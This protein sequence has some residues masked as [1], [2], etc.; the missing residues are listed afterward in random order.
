MS[1]SKPGNCSLK[2]RANLQVLDDRPV[3]PLA[4]DQQR[5]A[6]R[7]GRQQHAGDAAFE[8]VDLDA[9]DLAVRHARERVGRL[10]RRLHVRQIHLGRH[11]RHVVRLV[12]VVDLLAQVAQAHALVLRMLGDELRQDPPQRLVL[13]V[14]VLELL[15]RGHQR[16]PAALGDADREHDEERVEPGLL[17]DDAVL[18][19]EPG[20]DRRRDARLRELARHVEARGD[21]RRLDRVEHVEARREVAEAVPLLVGAQQPVVALADALRRQPLRAPD[22]EPPVLAPLVV[23]LAHR[24]AEIERLDDRLLDQRGAAGRLHHRRRHVARRDDRV[25]RRG[26]RVHQ[27]RLVEDVPVELAR[28]ATPAR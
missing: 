16:V 4:G 25:L 22:L 20:D 3:E 7:I 9:V 24:A 28:L 2:L 11:P 6:R 19:E 8:L 27:V 1:V 17:D 15:Q 26:R 13:V 10:H 5:N 18:G 14:V 12:H 23:D 21:D